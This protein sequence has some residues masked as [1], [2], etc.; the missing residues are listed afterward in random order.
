LAQCETAITVCWDWVRTNGLRLSVPTCPT[1][2]SRSKSQPA[3]M[4]H[5]CPLQQVW[6]SLPLLLHPLPVTGLL[7]ALPWH[8]CNGVGGAPAP[9]QPF[10]TG[11]STPTG[12]GT[13]RRAESHLAVCQWGYHPL[14]RTIP[15]SAIIS[16]SI[17]A[18]PFRSS[19]RGSSWPNWVTFYPER[20]RVARNH[21]SRHPLQDNAVGSP[22]G[23]WG[24]FLPEEP[25]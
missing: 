20:P 4:L 16:A 1:D 19:P 17:D 3:T 11:P 12:P 22:P 23:F 10:G 18:D 14:R 7:N 6:N 5:P 2:P 24:H 15:T 13:T 25:R 9:F 21:L 8:L